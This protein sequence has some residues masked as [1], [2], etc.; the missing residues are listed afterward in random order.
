MMAR[1][2][3]QERGGLI[4]D[5]A[6]AFAL[7]WKHIPRMQRLGL[8]LTNSPKALNALI[9]K[10]W[11]LSSGSVNESKDRTGGRGAVLRTGTEEE[12][13]ELLKVLE[14]N[15]EP[16]QLTDD[17]STLHIHDRE[18]ISDSE[19]ENIDKEY[20]TN[21]EE[22]D[23]LPTQLSNKRRNP[24]SN[25]SIN[26]TNENSPSAKRR[27]SDDDNES[28]LR[29]RILVLQEENKQLK[30]KMVEIEKTWMPRPEPGTI[31]Y[32][33]IIVSTCSGEDVD[34]EESKGDK[35]EEHYDS[36]VL[37][38]V[39]KAELED[40]PVLYGTILNGK[41]YQKRLA[42]IRDYGKLMCPAES[43]KFTD[44]DLNNAMGSGFYK[45]DHDLKL[46]NAESHN[47]INN[48]ENTDEDD[49]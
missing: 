13:M 35:L 29:G 8:Y 4:V 19:V 47:T 18:E 42:A 21:N 45:R 25:K 24:L 34:F 7:L 32:F 12:C 38:I 1:F 22:N 6:E 37:G 40:P 48:D 26:T 14:K 28:Y 30:R 43:I 17:E 11:T 20:S 5:G 36:L 23:P 10:S 27:R 41:Q 49:E 15:N 31:K 16:R 46:Q 33:S 39:C 3:V 44:S 2:H 9:N